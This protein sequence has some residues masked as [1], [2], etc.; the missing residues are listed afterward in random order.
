MVKFL[1]KSDHFL[2]FFFFCTRM[3][4]VCVNCLKRNPSNKSYAAPVD[5]QHKAIAA[6]NEKNSNLSRGYELKLCQSCYDCKFFAH[7][8]LLFKI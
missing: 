5:E 3:P 7:Y 8:F 4:Y 1:L 6:L 2:L